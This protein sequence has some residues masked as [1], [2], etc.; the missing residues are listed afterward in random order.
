M[1]L[2][3]ELEAAEARLA[4][5]KRRIRHAKCAE[6]GHDWK[7]IGGSNAACSRGGNCVC[8]VPIHECVKC[9]DC[10]YG[11]NAEAAQIISDCVFIDEENGN[12]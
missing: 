1:D 7:H 2:L 6:V 8:S 3:A 9:G 10:D 11:D 5:V 12:G 4:D